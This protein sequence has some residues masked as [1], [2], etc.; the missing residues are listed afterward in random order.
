[1][2]H[3]ISERR[4]ATIYPTNDSMIHLYFQSKLDGLTGMNSDYYQSLPPVVKRRIRAL[5]NLQKKHMETEV[6]FHK[7]FHLLELKYQLKMA[8][9][10][11]QVSSP[12]IFERIL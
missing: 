9:I 11:E 8:E 7:E 5:F 2:N 4:Y 12:Y 1:M 6:E 3:A 10:A